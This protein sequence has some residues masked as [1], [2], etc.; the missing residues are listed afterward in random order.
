MNPPVITIMETQQKEH[1]KQQNQSTTAVGA[2]IK[3]FRQFQ[4]SRM[5]ERS[6]HKRSLKKVKKEEKK[7][8]TFDST[9]T[10]HLESV[11]DIAVREVVAANTL[12]AE[13]NDVNKVNKTDFSVSA[14][15]GLEKKKKENKNNRSTLLIKHI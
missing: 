10:S 5:L 11:M 9:D 3:T 13:M 2:E 12:V 8:S 6:A 15:T 14:G 7:P 1:K 4:R